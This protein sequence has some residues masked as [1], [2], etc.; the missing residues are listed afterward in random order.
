MKNSSCPII[1][2]GTE[3]PEDAQFQADFAGDF[4]TLVFSHPAVEALSWFDFTDHRW[5][6][7][8]AGVVNDQLEPKPVYHR[9]YDLIHKEWHSDAEGLTD[10]Q[11][12]FDSRL[13]FGTYEITVEQDGQP[14]RTFVRELERPSFYAGEGA[15]HRISINL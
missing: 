7:A 4:Y 2:G 13:F 6:N 11:G 5:L 8:P 12:R 1:S 10:D 14:P 15:P 9:L 3:T